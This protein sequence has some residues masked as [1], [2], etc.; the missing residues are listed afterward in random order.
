M[1]TNLLLLAGLL[2]A[3]APGESTATSVFADQEG[4]VIAKAVKLGRGNAYSVAAD[5][6][7]NIGQP[8]VELKKGECEIN[9]ECPSDKKC[10]N[11]KCVDVCTQPTGNGIS[12]AKICGGLNCIPDPNT[13][14]AFKCVDACY[15]VTC[16]AGQTTSLSGSSCKCIPVSCPSGQ[17][18][19]NDTCVANC[20][21]VV[22]KSGYK[23]VSNSTGCCC[24][25]EKKPCPTN[26][27]TCNSD[28]TCTKCKSG[29]LLSS[30]KCVSCPANATCSGTG[31]FTC[32]SGYEK[33]NDT[34]RISSCDGINSTPR[35][36]QDGYTRVEGKG[37]CPPG[38]D[39]NRVGACYLCRT[40]SAPVISNTCANGLQNC[41]DTGCCPQGNTCAY[42]AQKAAAGIAMCVKTNYSA[43]IAPTF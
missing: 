26:C 41:G 8:D 23:A 24:E 19:D 14:H 1:K 42:Y 28:G 43:G 9:E 10:M 34:C 29:Y 3:V 25:L 38:V 33:Y 21:G 11:N 12:Y 36:C 7:I 31:S 40:T 22:C 39:A 30:G 15:N 5:P 18:L 37:C 13:P 2:I 16:P 4:F 6:E 32:K 17:R 35:W 27:S 20:S